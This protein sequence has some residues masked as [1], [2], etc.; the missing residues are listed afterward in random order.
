MR[1]TLDIEK[2]ILDELRSLAQKRHRPMGNVASELLAE[3]LKE[4]ADRAVPPAQFRWT[5]KQMHARVDLR[6][7][8]AVY[9]AMD[10]H[11][12]SR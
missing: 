10:K 11:G 5:G 12:G 8:D 7:R 3:A 6:D 9:D 1:T 4:T 2:P